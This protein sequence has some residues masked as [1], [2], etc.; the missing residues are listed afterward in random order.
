MRT[1]DAIVNQ[2]PSTEWD[3]VKH[4]FRTRIAESYPK[5]MKIAKT[6][7]SQ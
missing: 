2:P 4:S 1:S 6:Q 3:S 5:P 7:M